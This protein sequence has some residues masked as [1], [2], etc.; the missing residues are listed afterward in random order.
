MFL[1]VYCVA[2][3]NAETIGFYSNFVVAVP[4]IVLLF[5]IVIIMIVVSMAV[6]VVVIVAAV[7]SE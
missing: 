1:T 5:I 6:V 2:P 7:A 3:K 4:E